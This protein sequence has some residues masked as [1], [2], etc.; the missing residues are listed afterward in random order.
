[1]RDSITYRDSRRYMLGH[2]LCHVLPSDVHT[3]SLQLF[4]YE[5]PAKCKQ[6]SV[7]TCQSVNI[8]ELLIAEGEVN[9]VSASSVVTY[10]QH[11]VSTS[12]VN[13]E[14]QHQLIDIECQHKRIYSSSSRGPVSC[15]AFLLE[16]SDNSTALLQ[17]LY[18]MKISIEKDS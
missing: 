11:R 12:S 13:I 9:I 15:G 17:C 5:V 18:C 2:G 14:C 10:S 16:C 6:E 3:A 7:S 8:E 4:M 1:M